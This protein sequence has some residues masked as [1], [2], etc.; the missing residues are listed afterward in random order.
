MLADLFGISL[1]SGLTGLSNLFSEV[2]AL[3][4]WLF[5]YFHRSV[6]VVVLLVI[7]VRGSL[8]PT[9]LFFRLVT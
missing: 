5:Q 6:L 8:L 3:V 4:A 2:S 9:S 7:N 1:Q